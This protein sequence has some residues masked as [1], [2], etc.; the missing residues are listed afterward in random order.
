[1][2]KSPP[3]LIVACLT[4]AVGFVSQVASPAADYY[5]QEDMP[6]DKNWTTPIS[7]FSLPSGGGTNPSSYPAG[8]SGNNFRTNGFNL[9]LS[10]TTFA[11]NSVILGPMDPEKDDLLGLKTSAGQTA[12]LPVLNSLGAGRIMQSTQEITSTLQVNNFSNPISTRLDTGGG[13]TRGLGLSIGTLTGSGD[14]YVIGGGTVQIGIITG[15]AFTGNILW[16][17]L[18]NTILEFTNDFTSGGKLIVPKTGRIKLHQ[19]V[20]FKNVTINGIHL[21]PGTHTFASLESSFPD[22]MLDGGSGS[23]VVQTS[24]E[25]DLDLT[26]YS[27]SFSDEFSSTLSVSDWGYGTK[28]IAHKPDKQ[29]VGAV[30]FGYVPPSVNPYSIDNGILSL[31][32]SDTNP[33]AGAAAWRSGTISSIAERGYGFAQRYGY[34]E[35]R[36]KF[37]NPS[38]DYM[39]PS[40]WLLSTGAFEIPKIRTAELDSVEYYGD[41]PESAFITTHR[42]NFGVDHAMGQSAWIPSMTTQFHTYGV[43]VKPDVITYFID[44]MRVYQQPNFGEGRSPLFPLVTYAL[45]RVPPISDE[46]LVS[47][48]EVDYV[49][50]YEAP[51]SV[52]GLV[53]RNTYIVNAVDSQD[54]ANMAVK[55]IDGDYTTVWT[56]VSGVPKPH[57]IVI[58]LGSPKTVTGLRYLPR[59]MTGTL[60]GLIL[61][62]EISVSSNGSTF[63]PVVNGNWSNTPLEKSAIFAPQSNVRYVALRDVGNNG[64]LTAAAEINVISAITDGSTTTPSLPLGV[65]GVD[66]GTPTLAGYATESNGTYTLQASGA[67]ITGTADQFQYVYTQMTGDGE[68]KARV[69]SLVRTNDWAKAG[70]MMRETLATNSEHAY[71]LISA[72]GQYAFQRRLST[73]GS[74]ST[75]AAVAAIPYWVRMV[76]SGSTASGGGTFT[77]Y[78]SA[79]GTNWTQVGSAAIAMNPTIYVGLAVTAHNN[80]QATTAVIS[81]ITWPGAPAPTVTSADIGSPGLAGSTSESGGT[82][83]IQAGGADITGVSDQ[84][85]YVYKQLNGDGAIT[86]RVSSLVRT[87]DW[88]K[89]GVMMR[90]T[91]TNNSRHASTLISGH[92]Q[93]AFQRRVSIGGSTTTSA[94]VAGIPYWVRLVRTNSSSP[95]G[96]IFTSYVSTNGTSWTQVGSVTMPMNQTIYVGLAVTSHTNASLTTAV[97]D[98]VTW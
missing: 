63:T 26:D 56:S 47:Y 17:S 62:Y 72:H 37:P 6:A 33:T 76:R 45:R 5:L 92:G 44:G 66:V 94:A 98:N 82:Y 3:F 1:M 12:V 69:S 23:I 38:M 84:F 83:T 31:K 28:W 16:G 32:A 14:F 50:V 46:N 35:T 29:G 86:A 68:I 49:R 54:A 27:L 70:V 55:A 24:H 41:K 91:L 77:S 85:R 57:R 58:D 30:G 15:S 79:D 11:G 87:H 18:Q 75:T 96:S 73:G 90:E 52:T 19:N 59:Q 60:E 51:G 2:K 43:L 71:T 9:R 21:A 7:W 88:A 89:A 95:G 4:A 8:F 25:P 10:A 78:V 74:T 34:F 39:W 67:D 61:S 97:I 81:S 48:T 65:T 93:Y 13:G 36:M 64:T 40:F 42:W 53:P 80:A 22:Q 20:T